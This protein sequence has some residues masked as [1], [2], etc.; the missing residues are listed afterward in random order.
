MRKVILLI[1]LLVGV[2][3]DSNKLEEICHVNY[4]FPKAITLND[5]SVLVLSTSTSHTAKASIMSVYDRDG[6]PVYGNETFTG[7][8][9]GNAELVQSTT[10]AYHLV[11]HESPDVDANASREYISNFNDKHSESADFTFANQVLQ[12][13]SVLNLQNG[14]IAVGAISQEGTDGKSIGS[15]NLVNPS[16]STVIQG[17]TFTGYSKYIS[18]TEPNKNNLYC[19]YVGYEDPFISKLKVRHYSYKCTGGKLP[20][21]QD[22]KPGTDPSAKNKYDLLF[23]IDSTSSMYGTINSVKKYAISIAEKLN[24]ELN[25]FDIKYGAVYYQDPLT[26]KGE[27]TTSIDFT[28]D[29][30]AFK[31]FISKQRADGGGDIPE[32]WVSAYEEAKKLSWRDGIKLII[33]I[34]DAGAHGPD[35]SAKDKYTD[36]QPKLDNLAKEFCLMDNLYIKGF[37]IGKRST[38]SFE[39]MGA[40]CTEYRKNLTE[41]KKF[42]G[43][44]NDFLEIKEFDQTNTDPSYF[45]DMVVSATKEISDKV[46]MTCE[47]KFEKE[48]VIKTFYT[49]F[50][51]LKTLKLDEDEFAILFQSGKRPVVREYGDEGHDLFY[52]QLKIQDDGYLNSTRYEYL[53]DYCKYNEKFENN[54]ADLS[55]YRNKKIY[56]ACENLKNKLHGMILTLDDPKIVHFDFRGESLSHPVFA[57]FG[58]NLGLFYTKEDKTTALQILNF[59]NCLPYYKDPITVPIHFSAEVNLF[60]YANFINPYPSDEMSKEVQIFFKNIP[61]ELE[62]GVQRTKVKINAEERLSVA[63]TTGPFEIFNDKEGGDY[64]LSYSTLYVDDVEGEI[65][66]KTCKL[67]VKTPVCYSGC[68]SCFSERVSPHDFCI[69]DKCNDGYYFDYDSSGAMTDY[70]GKTFNCP[71]C[72]IACTLCDKGPEGYHTNCLPKKCDNANGYFYVE[73]DQTLC[74]NETGIRKYEVLPEIDSAYFLYND[75]QLKETYWKRCH[76]HCSSCEVL[77]NDQE[78]KCTY[79]KNNKNY[80]GYHFIVTEDRDKG[81]C[82][83]NKTNDGYFVNTTDDN[84]YYPCIDGCKVCENQV[85]CINCYPNRWLE[86]ETHDACRFDCQWYLGY[87]NDSWRCENCKYYNGDPQDERYHYKQVCYEEILQGYHVYNDTYNLLTICDDENRC[88]TCYEEH[89]AKCTQCWEDQGMYKEHFLDNRPYFN[90]YTKPECEVAGIADF[91]VSPRLCR[92]CKLTGESQNTTMWRDIPKNL[93]LHCIE[94]DPRPNRTYVANETYHALDSCYYPCETCEMLGNVENHRCTSCREPDKYELQEQPCPSGGTNCVR[95]IVLP[96]QGG[97]YWHDY[98][99]NDGYG[100]DVCVYEDRCPDHHPYLYVNT[101]ECVD[102]CKFATFFNQV[103]Y[104]NRTENPAATTA[105]VITYLKN[106]FNAIDASLS[107]KGTIFADI[108]QNVFNEYGEELSAEFNIDFEVAKT[109]IGTGKPFKLPKSKLIKSNNDEYAI[110]FTSVGLQKEELEALA[111]AGNTSAQNSKVELCECENKLKE[112]YNISAEEDLMIIKGDV[113]RDDLL[114]YVATQ[115]EYVVFSTSLGKKLDLDVCKKSNALINILQSFSTGTTVTTSTERLRVLE[116]SKKIGE[117]INAALD[118]KYDPLDTNSVFYNDVCSPFTS[119]DGTDVVIEDR[120][121]DYFGNLAV[122]QEGCTYKGFN[123]DTRMYTCQCKAKNIDDSTGEVTFVAPK[124]GKDFKKQQRN[125]NIAVFKCSKQVFSSKGMKNN[126]GSIVLLILLVGLLASTGIYLYKGNEWV[127]QLFSKYTEPVKV[128]EINKV[129]NK[130][131]ENYD[132]TTDRKT[133]Q[134]EIKYDKLSEEQLNAV[135]YETFKTYD[136]R[137]MI[138]YYWSLIKQ[139]Q[140][141]I[142][143]FFSTTEYNL[144]VV[145]I[146]LFILFLGFFFTFNALFYT[147]DII[148]AVYKYKGNTTAAI[149]VPNLILSSLCC[150]IANY[151]IR[152]FCLNEKDIIALGINKNRKEGEITRLTKSLKI[153]LYI[154]FGISIVLMGIFWYYVSAFCAVFKNSQGHYFGNVLITFIICNLYPFVFSWIAPP[155]RYKSKSTSKGQTLYK[156]SQILAFI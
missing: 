44:V 145:R 12:K 54:N 110:E 119:E 106:P 1:T 108:V 112:F 144:R 45:T 128:Q 118:N 87:N 131:K 42:T 55:L 98:E 50:D 134:I 23:I 136:K 97:L 34:A 137:T 135:D 21:G 65:I 62:I 77:G 89:T 115:V 91:T 129:E 67:N 147:D 114:S 7:S 153:R 148:K 69:G 32:D 121:S 85:Q 80:E 68:Y 102:S 4:R 56:I 20:D 51:Y 15:L 78:N 29:L 109:F 126:F 36:E 92:N 140:L 95:I 30:N 71:K 104:L 73:E 96:C 58:Q 83:N 57:K 24:K 111:K 3:S 120:K 11:Y 33:H 75:T 139:K 132:P 9:A 86:Y 76:K 90:C 142:F 59:P 72:D 155:L 18:C 84:N 81:N 41:A 63:A 27:K 64:V 100:D 101:H 53:Y 66:G 105:Q 94:I 79:C 125:S 107:I 14:V 2:L 127:N 48:Q 8:F 103:C 22:V 47:L 99:A 122:C 31:D 17:E 152:F 39:R 5:G 116:E 149:H 154:L 61:R 35:Y 156:V 40:Q 143:T 130:E 37:T 93:P 26:E 6:T 141:I 88:F 150:L 19:A 25:N 38:V 117:K 113:L 13:T 124:I 28:Q 49:Q 60:G 82:Y 46:E 138:K 151:I 123:F 70:W 52:Y 16:K 146:A 10:N 43:D 74:L 133:G